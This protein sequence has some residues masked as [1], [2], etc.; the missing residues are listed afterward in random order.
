MVGRGLTV[1]VKIFGT[2][3]Q[4]PMGVTVMVAA[5]V[6]LTRAALK[7]I[8]PVPFP[9]SPILVLLLV[10]LYVPPLG[11]K[12]TFTASLLHTVIL[13]GWSTDGAGG[14]VLPGGTAQ[15]TFP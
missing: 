10:Q 1:M 3:G 11:V 4:S 9:S 8:S 2:P 15:P 12:V 7:L 14:A 6:V 13:A 5:W